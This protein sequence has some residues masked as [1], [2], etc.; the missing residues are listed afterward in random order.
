M[1][2]KNTQT[3]S[4]APDNTQE[5]LVTSAEMLVRLEKLLKGAIDLGWGLFRKLDRIE[6]LIDIFARQKK[7]ELTPGESDAASS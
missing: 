5:T 1:H 7:R 2:M 4:G 6:Q 3:N